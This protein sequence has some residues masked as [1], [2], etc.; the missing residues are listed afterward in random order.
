L[1]GTLRVGEKGVMNQTRTCFLFIGKLMIHSR[2]ISL[3]KNVVTL[4]DKL[5]RAIV[6][7]GESVGSMSTSHHY[8]TKNYAFGLLLLTLREKAGLTQTAVAGLIGVSEKAVYNWEAGSDYPTGINLKKLIEIYLYKNVFTEG[9]ERE[10]AQAVWQQVSLYAPRRKAIFDDEWFAQVLHKHRMAQS[11]EQRTIKSDRDVLPQTAKN[12]KGLVDW[13]SS[14]DVSFFCGR[15]NELTNLSQWILK[16]R[17]RVV[18]LLG[19]GGIGKTTLATKLTHQISNDFEYVLWRSLKNA[20]PLHELLRDC[21]TFFSEDQ[22]E[23]PVNSDEGNISLLLDLFRSHRCLLVLDNVETILRAGLSDVQYREGYEG[24]EM[25]IEQIAEGRHQSCVLMTSREKLK[26]TGP[27]ESLYSPVRSLQIQGLSQQESQ[28]LLSERTLYGN[29]AAWKSIV[30]AYA[31]NPLALKMVSEII[32]DLFHGDITHFLQQGEI[33]FHGIRHLLDVQIERL[34]PLEHDLLYWLA[35]ERDSVSIEVLRGNIVHNVHDD[36]LVEALHALYRRS[37]LE[38]GEQGGSFALQPVVLEYVTEQL[39]KWVSQEIEESSFHL[40]GKYALMQAHAKEYIRASQVRLIMQ[41][42]VARLLRKIGSKEEVEQRLLRLVEKMR[43][44]ART[45]HGYGG[46]NLVNIFAS[47][48]GNVR[49]ADF[50]A[51]AIQGAY[52][53]GIEAQDMNL[54][55][56]SITHSVFMETFGSITSVAFS[57]NGHYIATGSFNGEIRV[58]QAENMKQIYSF[59][60][61]NGWVWSIAFSPDGTILASGS[62]DRTIKLWDVSKAESQGCMNTLEGH[63]H[64]VKAVAFS[65][66]G[67]TLASGSNDST[68][69]LWSITSGQQL[70][71]LEGHSGSVS[72]V[73][74]SPDGSL[75]ASGSEDSSIKLWHVENL[76]GNLMPKTFYG[77]TESVQA[78]AFSPDGSL[79]ASGSEDSSIKLW[80]VRTEHCTHT[81]QGHSGRVLAVA[82]APRGDILASGS[83]DQN[84]KLW[85]VHTGQCYKTLQGHVGTVWSVAFHPDGKELVTGGDDQTLR[86]W[87]VKTG[88]CLRTLHGYTGMLLSVA[89]CHNSTLLLSGGEDACVRIWDIETGS[90]L[91]TLR[92]HEG[93][94]WSV[95]CSP[96]SSTI[97]SAGHDRTL[98]L[99]DNKSGRCLHVLRGH[100]GIIWSVAFSPDGTRVASGS[101]DG[102]LKLWDVQSG[103]CLATLHDHKH[104]VWSVAFNSDGSLL[105]SGSVDRTVKV[106]DVAS[107]DCIA[108]LHGHT[109]GVSAVTFHPNDNMLISG[110]YDQT[111]KFWQLE[112]GA[113]LHTL[114][115]DSA[116]IVSLACNN[117]GTTLLYGG[118]D[119]SLKLWDISGVPQQYTLQRVLSGHSGVVVSV[120]ISSD[121]TSIASSSEDG[122]LKLWSFAK[123]WLLNTLRIDRPYERMNIQDVTGMTTAQKQTLRVL[124]AGERPSL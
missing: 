95:A 28:Q 9:N 89:F 45:E 124:G 57:P 111:I 80:N 72:S 27:L 32:S 22:F 48:K 107:G 37:L 6:V 21:L 43:G 112:T 18:T 87:Q 108:T 34:S 61:H 51:L 73:A 46:G 53:Q 66:D 5:E 63:T 8:N 7:S 77:H 115:D 90:C 60:E 85:D 29:D 99:W 71:S 67:A 31:G 44:M 105:A 15:S 49:G 122:T 12:G 41:P 76:T 65:P 36:K 14:P 86:H 56:S 98:R 2:T 92:G 68:I 70:V 84:S 104:W 42:L 38:R 110:S 54:S 19:M 13:D 120:H 91:N 78:V 33:Y 26:I 75:L 116:A 79:L 47:V 88:V 3:A 24:Y 97:A 35:I 101:D 103:I 69:K 119:S 118:N 82:F 16:E 96:N 58:W 114:H 74:F 94:I 64:W 100:T 93:R 39:V 121:E 10:E 113:C 62:N 123:G 106:W 40:L 55:H 11:D 25:F 30:Q 1:L 81:L 109:E 52:L 23:Q 117:T 59:T 102:T 4:R 17:C 20:P 83:A 50:S